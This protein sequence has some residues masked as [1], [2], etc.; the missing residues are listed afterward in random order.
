M[1]LKLMLNQYRPADRVFQALAD[2]TR[3]VLVERLSRGP[4][5][6]SALAQPLA[7]SLPAVM[8]H[9][10]VLE[11]SGL[12]RSEKVGRVRTCRIEPAAF[13]TVEQWVAARRANWERRLRSPRRVPR[14]AGRPSKRTEEIVRERSTQHATFVIERTYDA[15]PARVFAAWADPAAKG[16][17]FGGGDDEA[18][19]YELDFRVGGREFSRG[20][21][22]DGEVYAY[23]ARYQDIV[24]DERIVYTYDM[25]RDERRISV[26]LA[27]VELKEEGAAT[28]LIY[29]EQ[30]AFL[31]GE[32]KP[33]YREEGTGTLL[34]ALGTELQRQPAKA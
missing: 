19:D 2:P 26:S 10:E 12:V 33:E 28:R 18:G 29:T 23:E 22:P 21:A 16:R 8:Q 9:L 34:D 17:W 31:D 5:S 11:A 30:G 27:T 6:V 3:R 32:D 20:G 14:R 24:P 4:A 13:R 7:M 15:S 1:I 25:Q